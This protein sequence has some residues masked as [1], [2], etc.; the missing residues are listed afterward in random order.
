MPAEVVDGK[1]L[2]G[3]ERLRGGHQPG[4]GIG[5][6]LGQRIGAVGFGVR[7]ISRQC[8]RAFAAEQGDGVTQV[9]IQ[10]CVVFDHR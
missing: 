9:G 7:P 4:V 1:N 10:R 8:A 5:L 6:V 3:D 2:L